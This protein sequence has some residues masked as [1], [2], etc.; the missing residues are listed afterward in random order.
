[1][2]IRLQITSINFFPPPPL[3]NITTFY[4]YARYQDYTL[5]E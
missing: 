3:I 5:L 4:D 1:M 2:E